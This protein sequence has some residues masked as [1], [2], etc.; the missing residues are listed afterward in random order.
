MS[1][2]LLYRSGS[3]FENLSYVRACEGAASPRR[4]HAWCAARPDSRGPMK[5]DARRGGES[6]RGGWAEAAEGVEYRRRAAGDTCRGSK[7]RRRGR[8][9][10][11][12]SGHTG[13]GGRLDEQ[14][15]R[16]L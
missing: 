12:E 9:E 5:E 3:R 7:E 4:R 16:W 6:G 14:P 8:G 1:L 10:F 15:L 2:R 11:S 13:R